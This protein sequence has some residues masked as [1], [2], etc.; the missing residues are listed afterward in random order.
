LTGLDALQSAQFVTEKGKRLAVLTADDWEVLI[1]WLE[2]L[3]DG[4]IA[5]QAFAELKANKGN[6][7][8][9]GWLE[10]GGVK[11]ELG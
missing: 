7:R 1:D 10:W 3:E 2:T 11:D 5:R 8:H 9:D 6:R 4:Q